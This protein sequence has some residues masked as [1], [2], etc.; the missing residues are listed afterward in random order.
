METRPSRK[1]QPPLIS[2][3]TVPFGLIDRHSTQRFDL[4][5]SFHGRRPLVR[6]ADNC[7]QPRRLHWSSQILSSERMFLKNLEAISQL[8]T[9]LPTKNDA[10]FAKISRWFSACPTELGGSLSNDT[11][12]EYLVPRKQ[13][14]LLP[15]LSFVVVR[16]PRGDPR[17]YSIYLVYGR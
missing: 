15:T 11:L 8:A 17:S 13:L 3:I 2:K 10:T 14:N 5:T 1:L 4:N 6:V 9:S 16:R 7:F 12:I